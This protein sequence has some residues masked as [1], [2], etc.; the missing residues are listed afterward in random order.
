MGS[1]ELHP[2]FV[3][4]EG[5]QIFLIKNIIRFYSLDISVASTSWKNELVWVSFNITNGRPWIG[6]NG[7]IL[8][9]QFERQLGGY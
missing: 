6:P 9:L 8:E 1:S 5:R 3:V 2:Y 4:V 7:Q